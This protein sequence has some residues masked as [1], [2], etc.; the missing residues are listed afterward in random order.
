MAKSFVDNNP[1]L[2]IFEKY[3]GEKKN[4]GDFTRNLIEGGGFMAPTAA[5]IMKAIQSSGGK[6]LNMI[7]TQS[8]GKMYLIE[9][10]ATGKIHRFWEDEILDDL[11]P[12]F[13]PATDRPSTFVDW[14]FGK[15]GVK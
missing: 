7:R 10:P 13:G 4:M 8:G 15:G 11:L 5:P 2:Q 6:F 1:L 3:P 12:K 14:L 9:D